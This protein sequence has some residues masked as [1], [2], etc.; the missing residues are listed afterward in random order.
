MAESQGRDWVDTVSKLLIPVAIFAFGL[1]FSI[2]KDR[3]DRAAQQFERDT[4]Y[5]KLLTSQNEKERVFA[6]RMIKALQDKGE[7]PS[8]L[9]PAVQALCDG[10]PSDPV[11]QEA[12]GI[13]QTQKPVVEAAKQTEPKPGS[14]PTSS[15]PPAG[16][17]IFIQIAREDQRGLAGDLRGKLQ[18]QSFAV[19]TIQLV[20]HG[21][22][23][24]YIRYF[25]S[26]D[27]NEATTVLGVLKE[28]GING[29]IQDF[30]KAGN[31]KIP[32]GQLEVWIGDKVPGA[33]SSPGQ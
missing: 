24:T 18:A 19:Q 8:Q 4:S 29:S 23:N 14:A 27:L 21:T 1:M 5:V 9:L 25:S 3:S 30:T 6:I 20:P 26:G 7:F 17:T 10:L 33:P 16:G 11:T 2:Q 15:P 28:M 13:A 32:A 12:C 31:G 22:T